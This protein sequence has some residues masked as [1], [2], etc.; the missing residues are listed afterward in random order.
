MRLGFRGWGCAGEE[1]VKARGRWGF[2]GMRRIGALF[3]SGNG[4]A[5]WGLERLV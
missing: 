2:G 1:V 4:S 5:W 3:L